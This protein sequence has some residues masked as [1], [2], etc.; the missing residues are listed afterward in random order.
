MPRKYGSRKGKRSSF[1]RGK[2]KMSRK[3]T[4]AGS[5]G[6]TGMGVRK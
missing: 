5:W 1:K 4:R 2:K 6:M 3:K